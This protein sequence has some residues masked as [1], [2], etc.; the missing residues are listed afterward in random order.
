MGEGKEENLNIKQHFILKQ[1]SAF[2]S[3][4]HLDTDIVCLPFE[5]GG[6]W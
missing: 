4:D 6:Q 2:S 1:S 5:S 3:R